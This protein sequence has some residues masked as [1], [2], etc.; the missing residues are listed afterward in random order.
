MKLA[1]K[2]KGKTK[3]DR[4]QRLTCLA[5][6]VLGLSSWRLR[7]S[8]AVQNIALPKAAANLAKLIGTRFDAEV[9]TKCW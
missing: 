2:G 8:R 6:N 1:L 7:A 5:V 9:L 4:G 3:I